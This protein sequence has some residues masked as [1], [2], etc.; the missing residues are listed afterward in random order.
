LS[1]LHPGNSRRSK[2]KKKKK[3]ERRSPNQWSNVRPGHP[4]WKLS[5]KKRLN[6]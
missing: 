6:E 2:K 4:W 3:S 1:L 5:R